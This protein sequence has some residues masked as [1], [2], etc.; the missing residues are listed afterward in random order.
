M[1]RIINENSELFYKRENINTYI[2]Q[3]DKYTGEKERRLL[4]KEWK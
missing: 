1:N 4:I 3:K 2:F